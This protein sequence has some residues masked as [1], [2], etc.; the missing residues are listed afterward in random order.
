M[1]MKSKSLQIWHFVLLKTEIYYKFSILDSSSVESL[2][3]LGKQNECVKLGLVH[4]REKLTPI[5]SL[6][7]PCFVG[8]LNREFLC[9][10]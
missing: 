8:A 7:L 2:L 4:S 6:D 10:A 1:P 3:R 5:S 9:G